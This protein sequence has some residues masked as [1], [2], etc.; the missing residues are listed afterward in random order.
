MHIQPYPFNLRQA[1]PAAAAQGS[2]SFG[3]F[4]CLLHNCFS[5]GPEHQTQQAT[6][7]MAQLVQGMRLPMPQIE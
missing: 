2:H 6:S 5:N 7:S 3:C 4:N 1:S